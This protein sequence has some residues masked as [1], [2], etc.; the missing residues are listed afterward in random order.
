V[1]PAQVSDLIHLDAV[2]PIVGGVQ[3]ETADPDGAGESK[4][5][6]S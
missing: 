1:R 6:A 2:M 3:A 5:R 4:Y